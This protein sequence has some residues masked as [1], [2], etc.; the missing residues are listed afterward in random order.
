MLIATATEQ[1]QKGE[2]FLLTLEI[3]I[4]E[5]AKNHE[6]KLKDQILRELETVLADLERGHKVI[7]EE[8]KRK[9]LDILEQYNFELILKLGKTLIKDMKATLEKVK[10]MDPQ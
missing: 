9:D 7:D 8:L 5:L 3:Q 6:K 1:L 2:H 10:A 4:E